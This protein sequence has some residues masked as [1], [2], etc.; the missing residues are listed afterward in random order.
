MNSKLAYLVQFFTLI[1]MQKTA[2]R[3]V[4]PLCRKVTSKFGT[5]QK[6]SIF[7]S[8]SFRGWFGHFYPTQTIETHSL[9]QIEGVESES[10]L[11]FAEIRTLLPVLGQKLQKIWL[12]NRVNFTYFQSQLKKQQQSH[13]NLYHQDIPLDP[14]YMTPFAVFQYRLP[15]PFYS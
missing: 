6:L 13:H 12:H 8:N 10:G 5:C 7:G 11:N 15:R 9:Q 2:F 1:N 14:C 4:K 3:Y